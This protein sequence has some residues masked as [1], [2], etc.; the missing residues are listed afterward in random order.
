MVM[1]LFVAV[2]ALVCTVTSTA[3]TRATDAVSEWNE[4]AL[5]ATTNT[6]PPQGPV[7]QMRTMTIVQVAIHD[8]VNGITGEYRTFLSAADVPR[9]ASPAAAAIAAAHTV[10]TQLFPAQRATFDRA[11]A[12]SMAANRTSESDPGIKFGQA[13]AS[14]ILARASG[15]GFGQAQIRYVPPNAGTPGAW[16]LV[17][18]EPA[19]LPA[20]GKAT[21]W[22]LRSTSQFRPGPPPALSSETYVR[23]YDEVK[24]LGSLAGSKRSPEQT[25]I[26]E[27]WFAAPSPIW[28][29][30]ARQMLVARPADLSTTARVF[31]LMYLAASDAS[32]ACW[33]AKYNYLFWRPITAIRNADRD[34]VGATTADAEWQPLTDTHQHP[35]YPS[36]H[37]TNSAAMAGILIA[38]FGEKPGVRLVVKSPTNP[39]LTR[40]W[41]TFKEGLDEVTDARIYGGFHFRNSDEAGVRLGSHVAQFV[42]ANALQPA[43]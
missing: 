7:P 23:D 2:G 42:F 17:G 31:A 43:R 4:I 33:E 20:L 41:S 30:V 5:T 39:G 40:A 10:L 18:N 11:R 29:G 22:V 26:A 13:A 38:V 32:I 1:R 15:D 25:A 9:N 34:G 8:A 21:P 24:A 16:V 3:A 12:A 19:V 14:V 36:G 6:N 37:A 27:F 28:N 35:E